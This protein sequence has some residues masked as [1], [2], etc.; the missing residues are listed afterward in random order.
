MTNTTLLTAAVPAPEPGA[1]S[2]S[3]AFSPP[4]AAL[5]PNASV[6]VL[7]TPRGADASAAAV[8]RL[9]GGASAVTAAAY[10]LIPVAQRFASYGVVSTSVPGAAAGSSAG[11]GG[12]T[13]AAAAGAA[14]VAAGQPAEVFAF[15]QPCK[16]LVPGPPAR[17]DIYTGPAAPV[18]LGARTVASF[19][20]AAGRVPPVLPRH[21]TAPARHAQRGTW[22]APRLH[23]QEPKRLRD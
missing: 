7:V 12:G 6:R 1:R 22:Q 2:F 3:W 23:Q 17:V 11:F 20:M 4:P 16:D 18:R 8:P 9:R 5:G 21:C 19:D 10:R 15:I 14:V 13:G